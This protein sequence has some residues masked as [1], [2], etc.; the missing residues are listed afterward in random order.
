MATIPTT[1]FGPLPA[2]GVPRGQLPNPGAV[3]AGF[4]ETAGSFAAA[5]QD[6]AKDEYLQALTHRRAAEAAQAIRNEVGASTSAAQHEQK[7]RD[8]L[9]GMQADPQYANNPTGIIA[10]LQDA[11]NRLADDQVQA[12]PNSE[13]GLSVARK[14]ASTNADIMTKANA[15]VPE[16][17]T[18]LAKGQLVEQVNIAAHAA[19][20]MGSVGELAAFADKWH[21]EQDPH[22]ANLQADAGAYS[23]KVDAQMAEAYAG[24][25]SHKDPV[26]FTQEL[27]SADSWLT[28]HLPAGQHE[29]YRD[30]AK[31]S[32]FGLGQDAHMD[33]LTSGTTTIGK[34][35]SLL[36][37]DDLKPDVV[38]AQQKEIES[39]KLDATTNP[40]LPDDKRKEILADLDTQSKV[41]S[42]L[43]LAARKRAGYNPTDPSGVAVLEKIDADYKALFPNGNSGKSST[44]DLSALLKLQ[45]DV[46]AAAGSNIV[47]RSARDTMV[48]AIGIAQEKALGTEADNTGGILGAVGAKTGWFTWRS[49]R[50][51]GDA[52]LNEYLD[53]KHGLLGNLTPEQRNVARITYIE[54]LNSANDLKQNVDADAAQ[55]MARR[56]Q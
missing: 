39:K 6:A 13:I 46:A 22:I 40:N 3:A 51:S 38:Y 1:D 50:Q 45:H 11:L 15:W 8:L 41:L 49:A 48:K 17:G 35:Y 55:A 42:N 34:A 52:T 44:K 47:S 26:G 43:D 24:T 31:A 4:S 2:S 33:V 28:K 37:T 20:T 23:E 14:T 7:A 54:Q 30:L 5:G 56:K 29:K 19:G 53:P 21:K 25:R 10:P 18:Q 16:R 32:L 12:A 36:L 9:S 27:G